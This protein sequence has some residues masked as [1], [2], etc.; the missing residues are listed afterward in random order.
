MAQRLLTDCHADVNAVALAA[1]SRSETGL[2]AI[3]AACMALRLDLVELLLAAP[4]QQ[5][6]LTQ[7]Y[8]VAPPLMI[9]VFFCV[10]NGYTVEQQRKAL[11]ILERLIAYAKQIDGLWAKLLALETANGNRVV[12]AAAMVANHAALEMLLAAGADASTRS[13]GGYSLVQLV[14]N[15]AFALRAFAYPRLPG[16]QRKK[17]KNQRRQRDGGEAGEVDPSVP[18]SAAEREIKVNQRK[19]KSGKLDRDVER[20]EVTATLAVLLRHASVGALL[21]RSGDDSARSL[22]IKWLILAHVGVVAAMNEVAALPEEDAKKAV[23]VD[24]VMHTTASLHTASLKSSKS[25]GSLW[26]QA[27]ADMDTRSLTSASLSTVLHALLAHNSLSRRV[28]VWTMLLSR[29]LRLWDDSGDADT[30]TEKHSM[31]LAVQSLASDDVLLRIAQA[32]KR[33][34]VKMLFSIYDRTEI[35]E[36]ESYDE[37]VEFHLFIALTEM[38]LQLFSALAPRRTDLAAGAQPALAACFARIVAP[39]ESLWTFLQPALETLEESFGTPHRFSL[40]LHVLQTIEIM[41]DAL[42]QPDARAWTVC[43]KCVKDFAKREANKRSVSYETAKQVQLLQSIGQALP[44]PPSFVSR[45]VALAPHLDVLLRSDAKI[46]GLDLY[47][48][49]HTAS[50]VSLEHK[51]EYLAVLSEEQSSSVHVSISRASGANYV[52]FIVQQILSTPPSR[53]KGELDVVLVN[54]P[55]VGAG[56]VR[57][58]FQLVQQSLFNPEFRGL[59]DRS[60]D[61]PPAPHVSEIGSQW[62]QMARDQSP[63]GRRANGTSRREKRTPGDKDGAASRSD[64]TRFFPLFEHAS[65]DSDAFRLRSRLPRISRDVWLAKQAKQDVQLTAAD[66]LQ[67]ADDTQSLSK[68]YQC[69]GRLLGFAIRDQQP[70]D[71]HFPLAFWQ[72]VLHEN[73]SWA[74][75]CGSNDVFRRSLQFVLDH[76]FDAAPLDMHFEYTTDVMVVGGNNAAA[77]SASDAQVVQMEMELQRGK[78]HVRVDNQ[79]KQQYVLRRAEQFFFGHEWPYY[80]KLREGIYD[81]IE[82]RDLQLFSATELQT[83][84]RGDREIDLAALKQ[85]VQY[86][87][88]ATLEHPVVQHFWE[89]VEAFDQTQKEMLLTFWSGSAHAPL[90]GFDPS[91]R[92]TSAHQGSWYLD[93]EPKSK[94]ELCPTANTCD[95][96]LMLPPYPTKEA[97]RE[98]L[99]IALEHGA[100]GYD[101]M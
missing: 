85:A 24:A 59:E 44:L 20:A 9:C 37:E 50:L 47:A 43:V 23:Y 95:R 12:H 15:N 52:E 18:E 6:D 98:K 72:F 78:S 65:T 35:D 45:L 27:L 76:D 63:R 51:V 38:L 96:R 8:D 66:L 54:E 22:D 17:Q 74:A 53:L 89:V 3:H 82:R 67:D 61:T 69:A 40:V 90:F 16:A 21:A 11:A 87:H 100:T 97:L 7:V 94:V 93:L 99:M 36:D 42:Q 57:E 92:T 56:V 34:G 81:V 41:K 1:P 101:R 84:I 48:L 5:V 83:I 32:A 33:S 28:R 46:L 2:Q 75:Y 4:A 19:S 10:A 26:R 62:L 13:G 49:A 70:L 31:A 55:G 79:N 86:S 30:N 64:F 68:L 71:A 29:S 73:V 80:K 77:E 39:L 25:Y 88:G 60:P 58:F 14:E 91:R